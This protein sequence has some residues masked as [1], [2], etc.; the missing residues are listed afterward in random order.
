MGSVCQNSFLNCSFCSGDGMEQLMLPQ[1]SFQGKDGF[2]LFCSQGH[3][4]TFLSYISQ[5]FKATTVSSFSYTTKWLITSSHSSRITASSLSLKR[6][7][8][9]IKELSP[10][11]TPK[12][13]KWLSSTKTYYIAF[14]KKSET[15]LLTPSHLWL[16]PYPCSTP[17]NNLFYKKYESNTVPPPWLSDP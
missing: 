2:H 16:S 17:E 4:S 6:H 13:L 10:T 15:V 14:T 1:S 3:R 12:L 7:N 5:I 11:K 9:C 8:F